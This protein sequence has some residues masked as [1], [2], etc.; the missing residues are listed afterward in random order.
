MLFV[1]SRNHQPPHNTIKIVCSKPPCATRLALQVIDQCAQ[2]SVLAL[3]TRAMVDLLLMRRTSKMLV[4][5]AQHRKPPG[6][7]VAPVVISIPGR[8]C[9]DCG[10][11]AAI[12]MVPDQLVGEEVVPVDLSAILVYLLTIDAGRAAAGFEMKGHA[13]EVGELLRAPGAF[14]VFADMDGRLEML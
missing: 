12:V 13:S 10:R 4:E 9:G 3:A 14:G 5:T 6:A 1:S 7:E 11:L 2:R 8:S